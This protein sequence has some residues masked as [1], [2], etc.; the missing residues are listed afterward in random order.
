M[1][2]ITF[3]ILSASFLV[4]TISCD[5][6]ETKKGKVSFG[7][8]YGVI[9]CPTN[10]TIYVDNKNIGILESP[11][12]NLTDCGQAGS[13]TKDLSIGQHNYKVE[14]RPL[15]GVGCTKDLTGSIQIDENECTKVFVDFYTI[16]F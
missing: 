11:I 10:V 15:S 8:N 2:K 4:I 9:N 5:K 13:L 16:D 14:I 3:W 6:I 7:A 12:E 1:K